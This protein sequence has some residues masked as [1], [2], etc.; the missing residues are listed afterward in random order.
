[1]NAEPELVFGQTWIHCVQS[2]RSL[3]TAHH[4]HLIIVSATNPNSPIASRSQAHL[5]LLN[6]SQIES[7]IVGQQ[8]DQFSP[9]EQ[10]ALTQTSQRPQ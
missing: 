1:M 9:T 6:G 5:C 7:M 10:V 4:P 3:I 2:T 8:T